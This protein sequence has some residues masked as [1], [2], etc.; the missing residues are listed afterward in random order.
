LGA[1][2]RYLEV[3]FAVRECVE[4]SLLGSLGSGVIGG[5]IG[6]RS[7]HSTKWL[8]AIEVLLYRRV[9]GKTA[10]NKHREW[11]VSCMWAWSRPAQ[12]IP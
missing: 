10:E 2:Q 3:E 11:L 4:R 1:V 12:Y 8:T 9:N 6:V 7:Q 5:V